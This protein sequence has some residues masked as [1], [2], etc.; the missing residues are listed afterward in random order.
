MEDA[1]AGKRSSPQ[2]GRSVVNVRVVL[3][4]IKLPIL[5]NEHEVG[6]VII[7]RQLITNPPGNEQHDWRYHEYHW[8]ARLTDHPYADRGIVH[9]KPVDGIFTLI[10]LVMG[11][12]HNP[13]MEKAVAI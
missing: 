11:Q 1:G 6:Q 2:A 5:V 7:T 10:G 12:V 8:E 9:H 4:V 13:A 3:S